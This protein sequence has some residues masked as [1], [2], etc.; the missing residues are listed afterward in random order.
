MP[1]CMEIGSFIFEERTNKRTNERT[2][3]QVEN[4]MRLASLDWSTDKYSIV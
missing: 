2:T 4:I 1:I 3:G